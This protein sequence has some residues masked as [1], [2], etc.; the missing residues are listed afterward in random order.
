MASFEECRYLLVLYYDANLISDE[1]F[2]LLYEM[3]PSKN[4]NFSYDEFSRFDLD[5][6][7]EA[8]CKGQGPFQGTALTPQMEMVNDSMTSVRVLAEWLLGDILNYFKFFDFKKNLQIGLS[9]V[10]KT[11]VVSAVLPNALTCLYCNRTADFFELDLRASRITLDES[12]KIQ[13]MTKENI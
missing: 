1:D 11:Y 6:M 7:S 2:L 8:E 12:N 10:G 9:S 4:P 3:F 5:N 13:E